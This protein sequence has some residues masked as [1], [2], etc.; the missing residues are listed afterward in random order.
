MKTKQQ[1]SLFDWHKIRINRDEKVLELT[2]DEQEQ[3]QGSL[4]KTFIVID[5][6]S[7]LVI[8]EPKEPVKR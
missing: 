5:L 7:S 3:V 8:G 6:E 2:V 4:P 1:I